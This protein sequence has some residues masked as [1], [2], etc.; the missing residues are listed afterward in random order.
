MKKL[1]VE[2][3]DDMKK[4][5]EKEKPIPKCWICMD[6]GLVYY[7]KKVNGIRYEVAAKC[8]CSKGQK[9]GERVGYI[10]NVIAEDI[11]NMNFEYFNKKH[12]DEIKK[13]VS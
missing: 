11:A 6:E 8:R 2:I 9:I 3:I 5:K 13:I 12:P 1:V 10:P 7:D 4:E